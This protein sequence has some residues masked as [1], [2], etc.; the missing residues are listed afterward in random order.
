MTALAVVLG[1]ESLGMVG[2]TVLL[3]VELLAPNSRPY[4]VTSAVALAV[5][6]AIAA[7]GLALVTAGTLRV[8]HWSRSAAIVW[9]IVQAFV[10]LQAFQGAGARPDLG[11]L[12]IVPAVVALVLLFRRDVALA[13]QRR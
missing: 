13:T 4:S 1:I 7:A 10:G 3:L 9:Q 12:L 5:F 11:A 8:A 6:A 2:I